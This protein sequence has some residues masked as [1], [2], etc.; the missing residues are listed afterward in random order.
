MSATTGGG[1][2]VDV[3][4]SCTDGNGNPLQPRS[5]ACRRL[6]RVDG[7]PRPLYAEGRR[8]GFDT[9][10]YTANLGAVQAPPATVTVTVAA[11][12][13]GPRRRPPVV[14]PPSV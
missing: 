8:V 14:P 7:E 5:A 13:Q 6:G 12:R 10:T 2:A 11:P 9:F 3:T 4:L 1:T